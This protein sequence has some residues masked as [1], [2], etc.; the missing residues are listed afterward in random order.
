MLHNIFS[1][2]IS[3]DGILMKY[4]CG[5]LLQ[6]YLICN[7]ECFKRCI[8]IDM[9]SEFFCVKD[10][11]YHK[12][13]SKLGFLKIVLKNSFFFVKYFLRSQLGQ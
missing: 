3:R 4:L 13:N 9:F 11:M 12:G 1:W 7:T 10:S 6:F 2:I 5:N 8:S